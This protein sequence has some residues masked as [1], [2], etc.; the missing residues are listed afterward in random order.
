MSTTLLRP[1]SESGNQRSDNPP[2][3]SGLPD[4]PLKEDTLSLLQ[5]HDAVEDCFP[6]YRYTD[7]SEQIVAIL[8]TTDN[9]SGLAVYN[10]D[11]NG[12]EKL[13]E[14]DMHDTA[15]GKDA[16]A[17][18]EEL[19]NQETRITEIH[20]SD[21]IEFIYPNETGVFTPA[22]EQLTSLLLSL[23][24]APVSG[25][26][27]EEFKRE[28]EIG[29]VMQHLRLVE[30]DETVLLSLTFYDMNDETEKFG[31]ASF[32]PVTDE[33]I[34]EFTMD[35]S[36]LQ[37]TAD[38]EFETEINNAFETMTDRYST[39]E[40]YAVDEKQYRLQID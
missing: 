40:L 29:T 1:M 6:V 16:L 14:T 39:D 4:K 34:P 15:Y 27:I 3:F 9:T 36:R 32:D 12:W 13:F 10:P 24:D 21:E 31:I 35:A 5:Q 30:S 33:W 37:N 7:D 22:D 23:P 17:D 20:N 2:M 19:T 26:I 11:R 28:P 8:V 38:T 25:G 18:R